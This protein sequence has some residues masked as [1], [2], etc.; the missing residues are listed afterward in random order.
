VIVMAFYD[1]FIFCALTFYMPS[2]YNNLGEE[3]FIIFE[4]ISLPVLTCCGI[5][6]LLHIYVNY[7]AVKFKRLP[8]Y[9]MIFAASVFM[10]FIFSLDKNICFYGESGWRSGIYTYL[11]IIFASI[12]TYEAVSIAKDIMYVKYI[13]MENFVLV[14]SIPAFLCIINGL[15]NI[16]KVYPMQYILALFD[17]NIEGEIAAS[18]FISSIG[19]INWFCGFLSVF[20][21][22]FACM[23]FEGSKNLLKKLY[24]YFAFVVCLTTALLQGAASILL[25]I[26]SIYVILFLIVIFFLSSK[27]YYYYRYAVILASLSESI[28]IARILYVVFEGRYYYDP[29]DNLWLKVSNFKT[30]IVI[31]L[32]VFMVIIYTRYF[33]KYRTINIKKIQIYA[34]PF[35]YVTFI[36]V[37]IALQYILKDY[38]DIKYVNGRNISWYLGFE[39]FK[40]SDF[41]HKIFGNGFDCFKTALYSHENLKEISLKN[42]AGKNLTNAHGIF[43]NILVERGIFGLFAAVFASTSILLTNTKKIYNEINDKEDSNVNNNIYTILNILLLFSYTANISVSF[44]QI[45]SIVYLSLIISLTL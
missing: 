24:V 40:S 22:L 8:K 1:V 33:K 30:A 41:I 25:S 5:F 38:S 18:G 3:K 9:L 39:I 12:L 34:I 29:S 11:I 31:L 20:T 28:I 27:S 7:D 36:I 4:K 6:Y 35:I 13:Y 23:C 16:F 44:T 45:T 17:I 26:A 14:L 37:A 15:F 42:F 43:V 2:G 19:N 10:S 32:C 21:P